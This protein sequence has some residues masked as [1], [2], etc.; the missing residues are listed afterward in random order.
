MN[1]EPAARAEILY[2][3]NGIAADI[4]GCPDLQ[5]RED[6]TARDVN[7]WDSL[8]HVQIVVAV[9]NAFGVRFNVTE[10]SQLENAGSLIDLIERRISGNGGRG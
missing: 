9:E 8:S 6:T 4:L 10:I 7:G 3:I 1:R 2:T 5:L